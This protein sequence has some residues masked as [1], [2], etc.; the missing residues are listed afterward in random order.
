MASN[1][2]ATDVSLPTGLASARAKLVYFYVATNGGA[3]VEQ[4]RDDLD[5]KKGTV[6]SITG[7]LREQGHLERTDAGFELA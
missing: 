5:I 2:Q 4:L 1:R 3:T 6:L 7:M